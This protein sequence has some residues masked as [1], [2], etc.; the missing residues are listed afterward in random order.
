M[1][2]LQ[3]ETLASAEAGLLRHSAVGGVIL[4]SRNY[5]RP[6][7][8]RGLV[9]AIRSAAGRP[10]L[11]AI[12]QEG[13]RVQR[14]RAGFSALPP[15]RTLGTAHDSDPGLAMER[16]RARGRLLALELHAVGIDFSFAPVVDVDY[17][18]SDVI[19][20]RA[21]HGDPEVVSILGAAFVQ[22]AASAGMA[23]VAKHF[24][25]HGWVE[26]D[27]HVEMPVDD[28]DYSALLADLVPFERLFA[29]GAGAVMTAHVQYPAVDDPTP[30]YSRRWMREELRRRMGFSGAIFADD[31]SM[32]G[33]GQAGDLGQRVQAAL[34]AGC[35]MLPI[36]NDPDGVRELLR[37]WRYADRPDSAARLA[38]LRRAA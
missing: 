33:A 18:R 32:H 24:P 31:L 11:V 19:G 17:G 5:R 30:C 15:A 13:G 35:D 27:S 4:F 3:G 34:E 37:D 25:G 38:T 26:A 21:L 9:A 7:Q 22:G 14:M 8:V 12:D 28:R 6:G 1:I 10:V 20:D 36:C 23:C 16:A 29:A 2:D